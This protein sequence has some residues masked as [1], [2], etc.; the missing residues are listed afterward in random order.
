MFLSPA[1]RSV[2]SGLTLA[3][4]ASCASPGASPAAQ[5]LPVDAARLE[6]GSIGWESSLRGLAAVSREIAWATGSGATVALT[7]DGG[8]TW[9]QVAPPSIDGLDVRDVHALDAERAWI[10]TAGPGEASRILYT[11]DG[12]AHWIE[13][14]RETDE[15]SFLDGFDF[16][17]EKRGIAYG[18]PLGDG[19]FR[20][21][22]TVDGGATWAP[23]ATG[24]L[25]LESGEAAF[26][27]SGTGIRAL[28]SQDAAFVTGASDARARLWSTSDFCATWEVVDL[29]MPAPKPSAGA[30]S[31]AWHRSGA[32]VVVGGDFLAR[33]TGGAQNAAWTEDHGAT[34][35]QP[36]VGPRGQRAGSTCVPAGGGEGTNF[37]AT[38]QTGT[39]ISIDGGRT[40]SP[41]SEM[42]FHCVESSSVDG[43]VWFAGPGGKV[44]RLVRLAE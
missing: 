11:D 15:L 23:G 13:Q 26:A 4:A 20:I 32:G 2:A 22:V 19:R 35:H 44:A 37:L 9:D 29:P 25:A 18:D 6:A 17:D 40:W 34:W 43:T 28:G 33:E 1:A 12:G 39:D 36:A 10:M 5:W 14:R 16:W 21:L 31:A 38:G 41:F 30:F 7:T 8:T 3:L 42:G 24:P 27:A